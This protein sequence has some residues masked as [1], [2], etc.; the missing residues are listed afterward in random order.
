MRDEI[1]VAVFWV[2]GLICLFISIGQ[3]IDM[4]EKIW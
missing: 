2:I 1:K 4:A 3:L